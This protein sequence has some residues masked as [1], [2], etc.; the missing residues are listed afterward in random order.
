MFGVLAVRCGGAGD[1]ADEGG[2]TEGGGRGER[3]FVG[4]PFC[5]C[6]AATSIEADLGPPSSILMRGSD[7]GASA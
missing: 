4:V 7:R 3:P 6:I 1:F 2:G 5:L